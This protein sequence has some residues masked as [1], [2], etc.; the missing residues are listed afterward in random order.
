MPLQSFAF[1]N[2]PCTLGLSSNGSSSTLYSI[3]YT[4]ICASCTNGMK[5]FS[6]R[7]GF[8]P[9]TCPCKPRA[10]STRPL[11]PLGCNGQTF[12]VRLFT[13][14]NSLY[15]K[16]NITKTPKRENFLIKKSDI[17]SNVCS[18]HRLW[19]L[20]RTASSRRF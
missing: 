4:R 7:A 13:S 1:I 20:V 15:T 9:T 18:K 11:S 2:H 14:L 3:L 17:F 10:L 16:L 19:D 8:E 12:D 5:S 6:T